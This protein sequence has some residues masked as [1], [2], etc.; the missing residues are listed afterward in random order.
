M[1]CK[2]TLTAFLVSLYSH[3]ALQL[4][5]E[6]AVQLAQRQ[7]LELQSST[8]NLEASRAEQ[9]A[10][11][12]NFLPNLD[13][14]SS[15]DKTKTETLTTTNEG[16]TFSNSLTLSQN[17]YNGKKDYSNLNISSSAI[18]I[19]EANLQ[20]K[21]AELSYLL[22]QAVADYFYAKNSI[23]LSDEIKKRRVDNLSLVQLRYES[24]RENKGSVLLSKAYLDQAELDLLSAR[25]QYQNSISSLQ[26]I[27]N[28]GPNN[29]D[30]IISSEPNQENFETENNIPDFD[31]LVKNI[32]S[33]K[34]YLSTLEQKQYQLQSARSSFYPSWDVK[35][36]VA[37]SG[38]TF[39]AD[40]QKRYLVGTS[41]TWSL[42]NGGSDYYHSTSAAYAQKTAEKIL[43]NNYLELRRTLKENYSNMLEAKLAVKTSQSFLN[44]AKTRAEIARSKYNNG[45]MQFDD[46]DSIEN[47]LI[48]RQKDFLNKKRTLKISVAAWE[49]SIGTGVIK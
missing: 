9:K 22:Q 31:S 36:S 13:F 19:E 8:F 12:G 41:L 16:N 5:F 32:P 46:W 17:L 38:N 43:E 45:L 37:Y 47:E 42:F 21:K 6:E 11:R 20:E 44:A 39:L 2:T 33:T 49:K 7:N 48:S 27:L 24:G 25:N 29:E 23:Q 35:A 28:L 15:F 4:T 1:N 14:V 30:I 18:R 40:D 10:T 26:K 3:A 34:K